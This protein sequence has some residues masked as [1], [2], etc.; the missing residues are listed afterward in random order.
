[1]YS[2]STQDLSGVWQCSIPGMTAPVRLPGTLDESGIGFPDQNNNQW[3]PDAEVNDAMK[4]G[5]RIATRLTR[6]FTWEGPARI[7]RTVSTAFAPGKRVFL[8]CERSRCLR[9][10]QVTESDIPEPSAAYRPCLAVS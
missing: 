6:R 3:H 1:M 9:R 4:Q 8:E 7:T 10:L 5:G 2:M